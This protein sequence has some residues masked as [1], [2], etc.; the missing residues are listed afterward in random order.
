MWLEE[1]PE[2]DT[3]RQRWRNAWAGWVRETKEIYN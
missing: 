2:H 3:P 1:V